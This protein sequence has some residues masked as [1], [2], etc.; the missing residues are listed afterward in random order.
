[1]Q[2]ST[3]FS[4]PDKKILFHPYEHRRSAQQKKKK[5]APSSDQLVK[6]YKSK[7]TKKS[8]NHAFS[9]LHRGGFDPYIKELRPTYI[10]FP[11][12]RT[13]NGKK[14]KRI[15]EKKARDDAISSK[16]KLVR[17]SATEKAR[18][19]FEAVVM[20]EFSRS[21]ACYIYIRRDEI[22]ITSQSRNTEAKVLENKT[23]KFQQK[24][25]DISTSALLISTLIRLVKTL[26]P[27]PS[28]FEERHN[29][30]YKGEEERGGET[31]IS[32]MTIIKASHSFSDLPISRRK[33][34]CHRYRFYSS[35]SSSHLM[36]MA[37]FRHHFL[38]PPPATASSQSPSQNNKKKQKRKHHTA[39]GIYNDLGE[40][41]VRHDQQ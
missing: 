26:P 27:L 39:L 36:P 38:L 2:N 24:S 23:H 20:I 8:R 10:F 41:T 13:L 7:Q 33:K 21:T 18:F 34:Q 17:M 4:S 15:I 35:S 14:P 31:L 29:T 32:L 40:Y 5:Q 37:F 1:M 12:R 11:I 25:I 6:S 3:N 30:H 19:K 28:F 16:G 22:E 9:L